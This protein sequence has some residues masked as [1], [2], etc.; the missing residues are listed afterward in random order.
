MTLA[1][2]VNPIAEFGMFVEVAALGGCLAL[3][4]IR[5]CTATARRWRAPDRKKHCFQ[6]SR[7][8]HGDTSIGICPCLIE[9]PFKVAQ[10][11]WGVLSQSAAAVIEP[12][13]PLQ[14]L[15]PLHGDYDSL[16]EW[17]RRGP[18]WRGPCLS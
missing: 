12:C 10:F 14:P 15:V 8:G 18:F 7:F 16:E 11:P 2:V 4:S 17:D 5:S 6:Q 3:Q 13:I 9:R 1:G